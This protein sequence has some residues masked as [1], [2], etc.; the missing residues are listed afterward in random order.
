MAG[1]VRI[2]VQRFTNSVR[3]DR[4][5]QRRPGARP[6]LGR[7][8]RRGTR[9]RADP[10]GVA[11]RSRLSFA[12]WAFRHRRGP[13]PGVCSRCSAPRTARRTLGVFRRSSLPR[14]RPSNSGAGALLPRSSTRRRVSRVA[15]ASS[16]VDWGVPAP[17]SVALTTP[18]GASRKSVC[19]AG[20]SAD[21]V[22]EVQ[23]PAS[24]GG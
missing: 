20:P 13:S 7:P 5:L 21:P 22:R 2:R 10:R 1:M 19:V 3:R 6:R 8:A 16:A 15:A 4:G 17:L 24:R 23:G 11:A 9:T 12:A 14:P 18:P